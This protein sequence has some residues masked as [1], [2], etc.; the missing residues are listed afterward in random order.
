MEKF[1]E[2]AGQ[3][4]ELKSKKDMILSLFNSG[5]TEVETIAAV[6]GARPS[7]VGAVLHREGLVANYFDLYTS[8][9]YPMNVYSKHFRGKLGFKDV[10]TAQRGVKTLENGYQYFSR[11]L[12]RAGQHHTLELA[13]T[14][15]DRAR[16]T[17]KMEEAEIYRRWLVS[18]LSAP[19]VEAPKPSV[20]SAVELAK[21]NVVTDTK[22]DDIKKAA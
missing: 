12:D 17:G 7:Y 8:T 19:L 1:T 21:G 11:I 2:T 6:S 22:D 10:E 15:L 5:V 20:L 16:W 14:M 3:M 13:L 9:N 18:K 4:H